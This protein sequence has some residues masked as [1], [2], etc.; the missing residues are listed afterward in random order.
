MSQPLVLK[1]IEGPVAILRLN[2]PQVLN[3]LNLALMD[4]LVDQLKA[5]QDDDSVRA[6]ILTGNGKAFAAGADIDEMADVSLAEI[7]MKNQFLV[8]D[9]IPRFTK[10]LIAAVQGYALGGG[11]ELA[12]SCDMIV[13]SENAIFGQPEI[14]LGVM[15]GAG[16]TQRLTKALGK[17]RAME[18]LLTGKPLPARVAYECGL[19]TK[20]VPDELVMQEAL[21]LAHEIAQ[22]S[23]VAVTLIKEA[24]YKALDTPTQVG[25]D[26]ERNAFYMCFGTEDRVE[27]MKA[28]QEKRTPQFKGR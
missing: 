19:V 23:P 2:R 20:L 5:L 26:F 10:P 8:W 12:M 24:V 7:K 22:K 16:G 13:A 15:P 17:A 4:E 9:I 21:S 14:N 3:A 6:I 18:Y 25:M 11:C 1:N 27:G 28:F